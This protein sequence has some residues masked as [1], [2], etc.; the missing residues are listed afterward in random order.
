MRKRFTM[1]MS[2][3]IAI[4][5]TG[6]ASVGTNFERI[7]DNILVLGK[8]TKLEIISQL[9]SP[10]AEGTSTT[11]SGKKLEW[12]SYTYAY[13]GG[14]SVDEGRVPGRSQSFRFFENKLV[15]Y[16]YSSTFKADP[17]YFDSSKVAQIKKGESTRTDVQRL[18]GNPN[19][20]LIYPLVDNPNQD[21][22]SYVYPEKTESGTLVKSL[23][24]TFNKEGLVTDVVYKQSE[25][26]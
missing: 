21:A 6:C 2:I 18:I 3:L 12:I 23:L 22:V 16:G 17:T 25:R 15:G 5:L 26:R 13:A 10:A 19:G 14:V 4:L 7:P 8:T 1:Y 24:V 20:K 11:K 9:G